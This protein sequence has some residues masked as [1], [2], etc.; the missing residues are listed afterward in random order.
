VMSTVA[1]ACLATA[2]CFTVGTVVYVHYKQED[3]KRVWDTKK[4]M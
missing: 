2:V 4:G 3:D 1:K